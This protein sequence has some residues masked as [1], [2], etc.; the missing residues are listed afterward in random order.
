[1]R[2]EHEG[3]EE[4]RI[5]SRRGNETEFLGRFY[6]DA[7]PNGAFARRE[8][9]DVPDYRFEAFDERG[10]EIDSTIEAENLKAAKAELLRRG[11]SLRILENISPVVLESECPQCGQVNARETIRCRNC[12]T[13]LRGKTLDKNRAEELPS[14]YRVETNRDGTLTVTQVGWKWCSGRLGC[15]TVVV[16]CGG[17]LAT[18]GAVAFS[19]FELSGWLPDTFYSLLAI[20]G[21]P[22]LVLALFHRSEWVLGD[23]KMR[24][25]SDLFGYRWGPKFHDG[26]FIIERRVSPRS[27]RHNWYHVCVETAEERYDLTSENTPDAARAVGTFLAQATGWPVDDRLEHR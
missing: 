5:L 25:W 10:R 21:V 1:M 17:L 24:V 11:Y 6:Q 18:F 22:F 26:A 20:T 3:R 7:N 8:T 15:L 12:H 4:S 9:L 27:P 16:F 19:M 23:A 13:T 2:V 14:G